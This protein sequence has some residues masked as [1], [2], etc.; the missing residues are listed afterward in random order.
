MLKLTI[1]QTLR[2]IAFG[3]TAVILLIGGI[4][5]MQLGRSAGAVGALA[6]SS[7]VTHDEMLA[8]MQHDGIRADVLLAIQ[9]AGLRDAKSREV[10][11]TDLAEH[12]KGLHDNI[13]RVSKGSTNADVRAAATA[14]LP[15]IE[16]YSRS[17]RAAIDATSK[18]AAAG[19]ALLPDVLSNYKALEAQLG[20][21]GGLI[22]SDAAA[23]TRASQ[24]AARTAGAV[25]ISVSL[26][27]A[28]PAL[29]LLLSV[30]GGVGRSLDTV[31]RRVQ[32][33]RE[34]DVTSL[35]QGIEAIAKGD[36]A[37]S[38]RAE[39]PK[40]V[41]ERD[42]E[43]GKLSSTVNAIVDQLASA[44]AAFEVT[45]GRL[46]TVA[47]GAKAI[48]DASRRGQ[49]D[50]RVSTEG[51]AGA[52][53]DVI[54]GMVAANDVSAALV[55][56]VARVARSAAEGDLTGRLDG[57]YEG[58]HAELAQALNEMFVE[59]ARALHDVRSSSDQVTTAASQISGGAESLARDSSGQ[60]A[61]LEQVSA[62]LTELRSIAE[63]NTANSTE[64]RS[65]VDQAR[66]AAARGVTSMES[67]L[68]AMD[69]IKSSSDSTAKIVKTI[70]E[71]AFQTNLLALNAAVEAA[72]AGDAGRGF[73]V[74][75]EE[76]RALA[77]RSGEAARNTADLIEGSVKHVGSGVALTREVVTHLRQIDDGV[78][79]VGSVMGDIAAASLQQTQ[80]VT[81]ISQAVD[82]MNGTTQQTAATAEESASASHEL[83]AQAEHM[84]KMVQRF[85]LDGAPALSVQRAGAGSRAA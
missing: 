64:A 32:Q 7:V 60:A 67:L 45:R 48:A 73:A 83:A 10:A 41:I 22:E 43:I 11:S 75:A 8:D 77:I 72:R 52:F 85:R 79:R 2:V 53:K 44:M 35:Q 38:P 12:S 18:G 80:G 36:L 66:E 63:S 54:T 28:V 40:L 19:Q 25:I 49:L 39:T 69:Q 37:F 76:V 46:G 71:I 82:E 24:E 20:K 74:V 6:Q 5:W 17:A 1:R 70:D 68:A 30:A 31:A 9:S 27:S 50:A 23:N 29:L 15:G 81:E 33:L 21:L 42:D 65:L 26:V 59:L 51:L 58:A 16:A 78:N 3:V 62:S 55:A 56:D 34:Q 4:S 13:E 47:N 84:R 14:V 61:S 57:S